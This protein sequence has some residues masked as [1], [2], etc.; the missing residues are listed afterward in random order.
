MSTYYDFRK[1]DSMGAVMNCIVGA[2]GVGKT[3]GSVTKS[4][5]RALRKGEEFIYLRRYDEDIKAAKL[6]F[7]DEFGEEFPEWDFRV[8]GRVGE[9][10]PVSAREDKKRHWTR[11]CYFIALSKTQAI[12]S[13]SYS[14]VTT[15]IYDEFIADEGVQYLR[16][17]AR[18]FVN[19]Y[20]T[21]AR[22]RTNVKCYLLSNS[23]S[24]ANP[25]F[26][27]WK[28]RVPKDTEIVRYFDNFVAVHFPESKDFVGE[29]AKTRFGRFLL[30][31]DPEYAAYAMHNQF[32]DNHEELIA[33]KDPT[34]LYRL[35]LFTESG[36]IALWY[37]SV[38]KCWYAT[39]QRPPEAHENQY[40]T[41]PK[42]MKKGRPHLD[43][44]D[45]IMSRLRTAWRSGRVWFTEPETRNAYLE[46]FK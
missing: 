41:D 11:V 20:Y 10:S 16:S 28:I 21:V 26:V 1:I 37:S 40:T 44:S 9:A 13:V 31:S 5:R 45:V 35:T 23:V 7:F 8:N 29:T 19:F 32:A 43:R 2:R 12:K 38:T 42:M 14:R 22:R 3:Y 25:Y 39:A 6:T 33:A 4:I 24:I 27:L 46:A 30:A 15:I 18:T 36:I 34:A 17:E